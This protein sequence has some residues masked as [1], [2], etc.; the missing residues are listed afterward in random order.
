MLEE[1]LRATKQAWATR[2]AEER[3]G[4]Q[5]RLE[6]KVTVLQ[7]EMEMAREAHAAKVAGLEGELAAV[8][9]ARRR[10]EEELGVTRDLLQEET[11][12]RRTLQAELGDLKGKYQRCM[13]LATELLA[14]R[15]SVAGGAGLKSFS[16]SPVQAATA[17][18]PTTT[19]RPSALRSASTSRLA[20]GDSSSF[21]VRA[22]VCG[23]G[24]LALRMIGWLIES[25]CH[26][27]R[28]G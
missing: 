12:K 3:K 6:E 16:P 19:A 23:V 9:E 14:L 27:Y 11:R 22:R 10:V 18:S 25:T 17:P 15:T 4:W 7:R 28:E 5:G 8:V 26:T 2:L 13:E 24:A 21:R 1:D 20:M